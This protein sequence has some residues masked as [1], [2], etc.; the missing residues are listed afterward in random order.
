[1]SGQRFGE[2]RGLPM[3]RTACLVQLPLQ[4][5][6]LAP[7]FLVLLLQPLAGSTFV[8]AFPFRSLDALAQVLGRLRSLIV[9]APALLR[10]ATFMADSRQKYKYGLLDLDRQGRFRFTTR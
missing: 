7:E 10:H 1:M 2:G 8:I 5:L 9:V 3:R 4:P 6:V